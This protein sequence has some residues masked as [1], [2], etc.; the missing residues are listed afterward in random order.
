MSR[1]LAFLKVTLISVYIKYFLQN[2]CCCVTSFMSYLNHLESSVI[3]LISIHSLMSLN[4][5]GL[6]MDVDLSFETINK[7]D[8]HFTGH[9]VANPCT[10]IM[11]S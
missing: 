3:E 2:M 8:H 7:N 4:T 11:D 10:E 9:D 6:Q 1:S 5:S